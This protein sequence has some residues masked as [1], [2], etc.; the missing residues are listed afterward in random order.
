M[1][2]YTPSTDESAWQEAVLALARYA[3][4]Y[5]KGRSKDDPIY[6]MVTE[7]RDVGE[8]RKQY[9]SCGDLGHWILERLGVRERWVNRKSL[10][11]YMVGANV[12]RLGLACPI[13]KS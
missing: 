10:K 5:E 11:Q 4:G 6:A 12:S 7:G 3:C 13:S 8:F 9:S 2:E 1:P